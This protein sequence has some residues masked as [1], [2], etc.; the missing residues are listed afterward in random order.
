[1]HRLDIGG[2]LFQL[3]RAVLNLLDHAVERDDRMTD[4]V[5]AADRHAAREV[6]ARRD[7]AHLRLHPAQRTRDLAIQQRAD[8]H[9]HDDGSSRGRADR[10][11]RRGE[12]AV[13]RVDRGVLLTVLFDSQRLDDAFE[14][15]AVLRDVREQIGLRQFVLAVGLHLRGVVDR[16]EIVREAL[17]RLAHQ[18]GLRLTSRG[19]GLHV[20]RRLQR[21]FLALQKR[22]SLRDH[23]RVGRV[24]ERH[25]R[26]LNVLDLRHEVGRRERAR[27]HALGD[28][29]DVG[30]AVAGLKH[31]VSPNGG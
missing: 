13:Q 27:H 29:P 24:D 15:I 14:F 1:M 3:Q 10:R 8:Q 25:H 18:P 30:G 20:E 11:R 6:L 16:V 21:G 23:I 4:L 22:L 19:L 12:R 7:L 9:Q 2:L 17:A 26:K 5:H 31:R 28:L